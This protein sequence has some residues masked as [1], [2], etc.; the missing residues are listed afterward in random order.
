MAWG[1]IPQDHN[2]KNFNEMEKYFFQLDG[3]Q[4]PE[5]AFPSEGDCCSITTW[6]NI[7]EGYELVETEEH[8]KKRLGKEIKDL[9]LQVK[10][11]SEQGAA[12]A[13]LLEKAKKDLA[14][15]K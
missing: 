13:N 3:I 4:I 8:K 9:E 6:A 12:V 14:K 11:H 2:F 1:L 5:H 10:Y 15:T 7:P